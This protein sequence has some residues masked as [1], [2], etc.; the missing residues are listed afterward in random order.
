MTMVTALARPMLAG[1]FIVAGAEAAAAPGSRAKAAGRIGLPESD[2]LVR[3]NGAAMVA[4]GAALAVG[5]K[6]R[7]TS[8]LLLGSLVPT[9]AAAHRF[10]EEEG[11]AM[12]AQRVH[13]L[14][15]VGLAGGL[16]AV[17]GTPSRAKLRRARRRARA[18]AKSGSGD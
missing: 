8:L 18:A 10:W 13:F 12:S 14:K 7:L 1:I 15:N 9:T 2:L 4:G 16:V 11:D 17:L 6:P 5:Y 3:A